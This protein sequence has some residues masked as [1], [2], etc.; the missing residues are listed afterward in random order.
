MSGQCFLLTIDSFVLCSQT[1]LA[2]DI[3][4]KQLNRLRKD[5][6]D[7]AFNTS[8]DEA[9]PTPGRP[10]F[11]SVRDDVNRKATIVLEHLIQAR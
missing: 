10:Q 4:D 1:V 6:W 2:T 9:A 3:A 11:V 7:K 5:R 8:P